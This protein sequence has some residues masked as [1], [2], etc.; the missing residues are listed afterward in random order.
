MHSD[1]DFGITCWVL[2]SVIKSVNRHQFY[3]YLLNSSD[4]NYIP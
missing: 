2:N 3:C 4:F 1:I